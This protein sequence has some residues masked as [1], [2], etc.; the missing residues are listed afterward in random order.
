MVKGKEC[1]GVGKEGGVLSGRCEGKERVVR[2]QE[3]TEV[4]E[5]LGETKESKQ[6]SGPESQLSCFRSE[7]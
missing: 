5:Q 7:V 2:G 4:R 3:D 1:K 6:E